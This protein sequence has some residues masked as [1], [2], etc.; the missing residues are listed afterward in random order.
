MEELARYLAHQDHDPVAAV[1]AQLTIPAYLTAWDAVTG[2]NTVTLTGSQTF[3][4]L[5]I[6]G[7]PAALAI[8]HVLLLRTAGA[9]MILGRVRTPP[10]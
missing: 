10:F 1:M 8:G 4:N 2:A 9:P 7:D 3:S 6:L 5:A